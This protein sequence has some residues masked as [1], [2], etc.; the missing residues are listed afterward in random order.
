MLHEDS[1]HQ[2][3]AIRGYTLDGEQRDVLDK[4]NRSDHSVIFIQAS[5][6]VGKTSVLDC[7]VSAL[8]TGTSTTVLILVPNRELRHDI[9]QDLLSCV[10]R[11]EQLLW[12]GRPP[13]GRSDGLWDD[14]L[15]QRLKEKQDEVWLKLD[16]YKNQ[17]RDNLIEF[18]QHSLF[19]GNWNF[20]QDVFLLDSMPTHQGVRQYLDALYAAKL[21]L[22]DHILLEVEGLLKPRDGLISELG[23]PIRVAVATAD[24]Y[25]KFLSKNAKKYWE[26]DFETKTS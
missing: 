24:A 16:M 4:I 18:R 5:A 13:P 11:D 9:C 20:I 1:I 3:E 22:R 7:V 2:Y 12:L 26:Q 10:L 19:D 6:G 15:E 8:I 14:I 17:L 23:E 25:A 21:T